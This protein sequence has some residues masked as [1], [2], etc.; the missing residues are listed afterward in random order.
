MKKIQQIRA[1][2]KISMN[3]KLI[4]LINMKLYMQISEQKKYHERKKLIKHKL[5]ITSHSIFISLQFQFEKCSFFPFAIT[6]F[7]LIVTI[8]YIFTIVEN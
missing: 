2:Q 1:L 4:I 5:E 7:I 3:K 6:S 8:F